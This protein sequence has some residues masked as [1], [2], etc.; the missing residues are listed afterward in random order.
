MAIIKY[1]NRILRPEITSYQVVAVD[2]RYKAMNDSYNDEDY[3]EAI[4]YAR[5]MIESVCKYVFKILRAKKL[6]KDIFL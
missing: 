1:P 4:N 5:S 3:G 2:E 6:P